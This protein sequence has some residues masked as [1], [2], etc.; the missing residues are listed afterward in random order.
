[1]LCLYDNKPKK[2]E[3]IM[4][5]KVGSIILL[6]VLAALMIVALLIGCGTWNAIAEVRE[7]DTSQQ[8]L[9]GGAILTVLAATFAVWIGFAVGEFLVLGAGFVIS[10]INLKMAQDGV[11]KGISTA[12][13]A[14]YSV[15]ELLVVGMV[16]C[17]IAAVVM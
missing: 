15:A 14:F 5:K 1:M 13:F 10:G 17:A 8:A 11:I 3:M 16:V 2:G 12:F 7:L 6:C 9:P 4:N